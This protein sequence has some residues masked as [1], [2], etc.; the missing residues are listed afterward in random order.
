M[1]PKS[2]LDEYLPPAELAAELSVCKKT[3]D[4]W[5]VLGIGPPITKIGRK[6]YYSRAGVVAWLRAREQ[7]TQAAGHAQHSTA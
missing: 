4:R 6:P 1:Q 5:R 7:Q 2:L 3:L